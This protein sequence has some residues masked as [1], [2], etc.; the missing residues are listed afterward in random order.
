VKE[1]DRCPVRDDSSTERLVMDEKETVGALHSLSSSM[2]DRTKCDWKRTE[3]DRT[4]R[5]GRDRDE[6]GALHTLSSS[7]RDRTKND[8]KRTERERPRETFYQGLLSDRMTRHGRERDEN[9]AMVVNDDEIASPSNVQ[10]LRKKVF[11]DDKIIT[12]M[13]GD[14]RKRWTTTMRYHT[15]NKNV[16]DDNPTRTHTTQP[17]GQ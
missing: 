13:Y 16:Q 1:Q 14:D 17:T 4:A 3:R 7:M 6:M 8:W 5:H 2:R 15:K 10:Q 9:E 11:V 12:S